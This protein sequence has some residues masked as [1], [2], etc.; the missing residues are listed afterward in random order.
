MAILFMEVMV[1]P[2][3]NM[4][5]P[6][7]VVTEVRGANME[8]P[9]MVVAVPRVLITATPSIATDQNR[10]WKLSGFF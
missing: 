9:L 4:E 1:V 6:F 2:I 5:T 10:Q 8:T 3:P 7:M